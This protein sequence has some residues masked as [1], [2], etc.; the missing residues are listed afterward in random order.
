MVANRSILF[1][2]FHKCATSYFSSTLLRNIPGYTLIDYATRTYLDEKNTVPSVSFEPFGHIYGVV[3]ILERDHPN[4]RLIHTL[5]ERPELSE[6]DI[7]CW[8][9]DPRDIL[10]S[11]Y[12]SFG[13]THTYSPNP[14]IR[15]Y[16]EKRRNRIQS[17][18]LDDYVLE[19][20]FSLQEKF[21]TMHKVMQ[22]Y[23]HAVHFRYEDMITSFDT[24][25]T[26]FQKVLPVP[27]SFKE[28]F[29][30][31]TRPRSSENTVSHKRSGNVGEYRRKLSKETIRELDRR[32]APIFDI[33]GYKET[34]DDI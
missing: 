26:E 25:F 33:F 1:L 12:Y 17:L 32:F 16:Q 11:M 6:F 31:A 14:R 9:R 13:F 5:L 27:T 34:I 8:T 2:S 22:R 24:F 4:F 18:S 3:R 23:P 7:L 21:L 29:R 15:A 19:A 28:T 10:V 20:S 30:E